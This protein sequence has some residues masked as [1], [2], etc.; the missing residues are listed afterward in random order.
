LFIDGAEEKTKEQV[1]EIRREVKK[2]T[3]VI[4]HVK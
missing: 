1:A 4:E 3:E 2:N